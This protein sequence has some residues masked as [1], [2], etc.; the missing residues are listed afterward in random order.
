MATIHITSEKDALSLA[1]K[2]K[3]THIISISRPG[4]DSIFYGGFGAAK[5]LDIKF[6]DIESEA[7]A[8]NFDPR[9]VPNSNHVKTICDFGRDFEED[10]IVLI[11]CLLG[12]SR[13]PAAAIIALT[14]NHGAIGAAKMIGKLQVKNAPAYNYYRPNRMLM[15]EFDNML[16]FEGEFLKIIETDFFGGV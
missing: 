7:A 11:H 12:I 10:S 3:P 1:K 13:S 4:T 2:I 6:F 15:K 9:D 8:A 5:I 16:E 14:P